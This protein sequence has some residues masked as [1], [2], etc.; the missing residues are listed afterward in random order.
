[1]ATAKRN[2]KTIVLWLVGAVVLA[3]VLFG[4]LGPRRDSNDPTPSVDNAS[5]QGVRGMYLALGEL[6]YDVVR[7]DEPTAEL[8]KVDAPGTTLLLLNPKLPVK[9]REQAE[10]AIAGFLQRGGRVIATGPTGAE[11]LPGGKAG[12]PTRAYQ[13]MCVTTPEG[14]G[15]LA[16]VGPI[17]IPDTTSWDEIGPQYKVAQRCGA[18]AVVVSYKYGAGEVVWWSSPRPLTNVGV[19]GEGNLKLVLAALG[20]SEGKARKVLFDEYLE[21]YRESV[22]G[23]L[24]GLPWWSL[25]GQALAVGLLLVLSRGRRNGPLRMPLVVPRSSPVEF[26]ESMGRLYGRAGAT[27][28]AVGAARA[29]VVTAL[30]EQCGVPRE[31]IPVGVSDALAERLGGDWRGVEMHLSANAA[32]LTGKS[33]LGLVKALDED[34]E[35]ISQLQRK[36]VRDSVAQ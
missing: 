34:Y 15:A 31:M 19:G 35:R 21:E 12:S 7:W 13:A 8:A 3:I 1:M 25:G 36:T 2:D 30:R 26:A 18:D 29:R 17:E 10:K 6:G 32:G 22:G 33:A 20:G 14:P 23:L 5:S 11:L 24:K 27:E 16:K 9:S 28:A 4:F